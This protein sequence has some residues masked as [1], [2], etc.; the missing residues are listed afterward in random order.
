MP[1]IQI[2]KATPGP[3]TTERILELIQAHP[4]GITIKEICSTLNRPVS[5]VQYCLK[6]LISSKQIHAR[7]SENRMHLV[8]YP[9]KT[10]GD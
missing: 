1:T 4:Q 3:T 9:S 8:Y 2:I 7:L 10:M 6:P 5:M